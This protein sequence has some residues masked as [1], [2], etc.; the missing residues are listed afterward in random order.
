MAR[1]L[2][3]FPLVYF[4]SCSSF[5][6]FNGFLALGP[7]WLHCEQVKTSLC[8]SN[9]A[10]PSMYYTSCVCVFSADQLCLTLGNPVDCSPPN[11]S[12]HGDSPGK[13]TGVCCRFLFH[14]KAVKITNFIDLDPSGHTL[15]FK[16]F[17][18]TTWEVY[19]NYFLGWEDPLEKG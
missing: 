9:S 12:V 1:R 13:N 5:C 4:S 17:S 8:L 16:M 2:S 11:S 19:V 18:V 14:N 10:F 15:H 7:M 3:W 6:A